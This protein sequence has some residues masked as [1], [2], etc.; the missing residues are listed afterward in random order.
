[1]KGLD[2]T[3]KAARLANYL[4]GFRM[5]ILKLT[6]SCGVEHPHLITPDHFEILDNRFGSASLETVFGYEQA[7]P[8]PDDS[9]RKSIQDLMAPQVVS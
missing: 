9:A 7:I 8:R 5:E 6:H 3:E 4:V 1:M 2:P